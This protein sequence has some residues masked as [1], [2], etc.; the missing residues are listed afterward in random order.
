MVLNLFYANVLVLL[1]ELIDENCNIEVG[2]NIALNTP[3][4]TTIGRI[5]IANDKEIKRNH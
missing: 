1:L 3:L 4:I 5:C 2:K